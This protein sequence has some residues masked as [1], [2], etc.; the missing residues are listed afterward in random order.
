M[1]RWLRSIGSSTHWLPQPLRGLLLSWASAPATQVNYWSRPGKTSTGSKV[2]LPE[3]VEHLT[4]DEAFEAAQDF[5]FRA[6]VSGAPGLGLP[7][8]K[9][10]DSSSSGSA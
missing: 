4:G 8:L 10:T 7:R 1:Q 9:F 5:S 3:R 6:S 2:K